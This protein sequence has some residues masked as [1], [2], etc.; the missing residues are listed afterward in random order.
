MA[1]KRSWG[2]SGNQEHLEWLQFFLTHKGEENIKLKKLVAEL[3]LDK[4][5]L[6]DVL[7]KSPRGFAAARCRPHPYALSGREQEIAVQILSPRL[8]HFSIRTE[9]PTLAQTARIG[10]PARHRPLYAVVI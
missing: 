7:S 9:N 3:S 5:M 1:V 2:C 8:F 4:A 6:Q 10:A